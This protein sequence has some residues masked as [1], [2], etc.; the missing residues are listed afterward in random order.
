MIPHGN[1]ISYGDWLEE[2]ERGQSL[3]EANPAVISAL[4]HP[5]G[6]GLCSENGLTA[7][8]FR[9]GKNGL[10]RAYQFRPGGTQFVAMMQSEFPQGLFTFG[11]EFQ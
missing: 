4:I 11:R 2:I 9:A 3:C 6:P 7:T 8:T 5:A 10:K 1:S